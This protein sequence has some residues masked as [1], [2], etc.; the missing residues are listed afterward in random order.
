MENN[1]L[2]E[3]ARSIVRGMKTPPWQSD[4]MEFE[5][6]LWRG[7]SPLFSQSGRQLGEENTRPFIFNHHVPA[8]TQICKYDGSRYDQLI[9]ISALRV[10][11]KNFD[12]ALDIVGDVRSFHLHQKD[13]QNI[14]TK[15]GIWDL[16]LM[17][18]ACIA[19]IA[20]QVR[21]KDTMN[22]SPIVKDSLASLYQ[23]ISGIFM[24]CRHM[25][26]EG[27]AKIIHND[28]MSAD[29]LYHYADQ[30]KIFTSFNG[31]VCAG[32]TRKIL[33]FIEFC[34]KEVVDESESASTRANECTSLQT[35]IH[36]IE[37]WYRYSLNSVELD[38]YIEAEYYSRKIS[39]GE[40]ISKN[41]R[42]YKIYKD[43]GGYCDEILGENN[44][45]RN[46]NFAIS[47][48][49]RQNKLLTLLGRE[50]IG[51]IPKKK[52]HARLNY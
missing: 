6:G 27:D 31:M 3:F 26:N 47:V 13:K 21:H 4:I 20:F 38:C 17:S 49:Q 52:L 45:D 8:E 32:S 22:A 34:N 19:L 11:M 35:H 14:I 48:L 24:I 37:D 9:N 39:S 15:L 41:K 30:N 23:F 29:D 44:R 42:I 18:R 2:R 36:A 50:V 1:R 43:I 33:E 25:M 28:P 51:S 7:V 16:Y 46:I 40:D 12:E 10:A 5:F